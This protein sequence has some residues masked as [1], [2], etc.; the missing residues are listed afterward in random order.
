MD[1]HCVNFVTLFLA[2]GYGH[3][4]SLQCSK[5]LLLQTKVVV[6]TSDG[7]S[8]AIEIRLNQNTNII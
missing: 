2:V 8:G 1:D 4:T 5:M 6:M 7:V 3:A